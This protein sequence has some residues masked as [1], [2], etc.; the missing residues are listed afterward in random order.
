MGVLMD[1]PSSGKHNRAENYSNQR[2]GD[3]ERAEAEMP[4]QLQ[5]GGCGQRGR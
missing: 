4:V 2:R 5:P 1:L 3:E